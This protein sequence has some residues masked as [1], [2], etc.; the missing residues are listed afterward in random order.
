LLKAITWLSRFNLPR[1]HSA[2]SYDGLTETT[3]ARLD[4]TASL[5]CAK[6]AA[7]GEICWEPA[8]FRLFFSFKRFRFFGNDV[9][10]KHLTDLGRQY[11]KQVRQ[12]DIIAYFWTLGGF[13][14]LAI[15][16]S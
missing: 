3:G 5:E 16:L 12:T 1:S 9:E 2:D 15:F 7:P 6:V 13:V 11:Q 10:P 8:D 14:A 4:C